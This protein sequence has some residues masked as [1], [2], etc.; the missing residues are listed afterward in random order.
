M[1]FKWRPK[2]RITRKSL[3]FASLMSSS[4]LFFGIAMLSPVE[5]DWPRAIDHMT[6][7]PVGVIKIILFV[8]ALCC[9]SLWLF[10]RG[11]KAIAEY[12]GAFACLFALLPLIG[13]LAGLPKDVDPM[14]LLLL[15]NGI[16][17]WIFIASAFISITL[18]SKVRVPEDD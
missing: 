17:A 3:L 18:L 13:V 2:V 5:F 10:R 8:L 1:R 12:V 4:S 7:P 11:H 14:G 6:V 16:A 15:F 9:S